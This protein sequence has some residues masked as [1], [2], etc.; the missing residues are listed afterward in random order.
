MSA[1]GQLDP[2]RIGG[3]K[4][5]SFGPDLTELLRRV[6][7]RSLCLAVTG[8]NHGFMPLLLTLIS[9]AMDRPLVVVVV[10]DEVASSLTDALN[11]YDPTADNSPTAVTL[12]ATDVSP[13]D[14]LTPNRFS[15]MD[16]MTALLRGSS[17]PAV[18]YVVASAPALA[19]KIPHR[20]VLTE[21]TITVRIGDTFD[22]DTLVHQLHDLGYY[23]A[24]LVEDPGSYAV[25][26]GLIDI[27]SPLSNLP[28]RIE[29]FGDEVDNIRVFDPQTQRS[30]DHVRHVEIPPITPLAGARE[31]RASAAA[32][33]LQTASELRIPATLA[34]GMTERFTNGTAGPEA[35]AYMPAMYELTTPDTFLP[36]DAVWVVVE[37]AKIETILSKQWDELIQECDKAMA[38]RRIVFPAEAY[39][40]D[41][42]AIIAQLRQKAA[43][44]LA[45]TAPVISPNSIT[46]YVDKNNDI[47]EELNRHRAED[48]ALAPL[49]KHIR[50]WRATA[51]SVAITCH[52]IGSAHRMVGLMR[53]YGIACNL[54]DRSL[55]Y[56]DIET[57]P[58]TPNDVN[59]FVGGT[60]AG[61]RFAPLG[62]VVL[63]E[64]EILGRKGRVATNRSRKEG[65][66][67]AIVESFRELAA[68]DTVVHTDFGLAKYEGLVKL[69]I[70]GIIGDFLH[71]VFRDDD[72]L[73]LPI[74]RLDHIRK[75]ASTNEHEQPLLDKL[76]GTSWAKVT[77]RVRKNLLA[78]AHK[79][80]QIQAEREAERGYPFGPPSEYYREFEA[81]FPYDETPD[82]LSAI[83][84][85]IS[86]VQKPRPMDRLVCGDVGFGKTE[87]AIRA[88]FRAVEEG[89]QVAVLVPTTILAEQHHL[90]FEQRF[91]GYPISVESLSRY[92]TPAEQREILDRV[93]AGKVDVLIGTHRLL[94]KDV[95]FRDLGLL[96]IDEEHRFGVR[97]KERI[98]TIRHGV[99][100]LTLTATPIPR[101]LHMS[102][103]G[104]RDLSVIAT[105]PT[106]RLAI[107]TFVE[108]QTND[109][110]QTAIERE[111]SRGG[112]VYLIHNRVQT[113]TKRAEQ[114]RALVPNAKIGVG[115]GQ[116]PEHQLVEVMR[117]F[118]RGQVNVLV[119]TT[120]VES[121]L[122]IPNAN[123]LIVERADRFGL[124]ELYQLRGRVGRSNVRAYAYFLIEHITHLDGNAA[125]RIA[126]LQRH[127]ELGSGF[128]IASSDMEIR[129]TGNLLGAEQ[130][131][132]I[133][134]VGYELY[135][136]MLQD[137]V[138]ALRGEETVEETDSQIKAP[139]A[140][141]IPD[142]Y[143]S[144]TGMRLVF[145]KR[146]A[147]SKNDN[148]VVDTLR[149]LVDRC[150]KPPIEVQNLADIMA[151]KVMAK[152]LGIE[153][154][155][156]TPQAITL[157]LAPSLHAT[158]RDRIADGAL[159]KIKWFPQQQGKTLALK[160]APAD[161]A[162]GTEF[163][164]TALSEFEKWYATKTV[165]RGVTKL[166]G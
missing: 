66:S 92:R 133:E 18:R 138:S 139:I 56:R 1:V 43:L 151:A 29:F 3:N 26:G 61:F 152:R 112:Q 13:V 148:D 91:H 6:N 31:T 134:A 67:K 72:K 120:I 4:F 65:L 111:I 160:L 37:P 49:V 89:K 48:D 50:E 76:G 78:M 101:T 115:H 54:W 113:I 58:T 80:V 93:R 73:Y 17:F 82:Q 75:Y 88:A 141:F 132:N 154:V 123:T 166:H 142:N 46:L 68:G 44:I 5:E 24:P 103:L 41:T 122:D 2:F 36:Q 147:S 86:D 98:K 11:G 100:V 30:L 108:A 42:E 96:V 10:G 109:V 157:T 114:I 32:T 35:N 57:I 34:R 97:D 143:C 145:Y 47:A 126:V 51:W 28:I 163:L 149:D 83:D 85:V 118:S 117:S 9:R 79:L 140:A 62:L 14:P 8:V 87:V 20:K 153:L 146:F 137:A 39:L 124:A 164:V 22:R 161:W 69:T 84:D 25:R 94:Q 127:S 52:T 77:K 119:C 95:S 64:S 165:D 99:H 81:S 33:L 155:H 38:N 135:L 128:Q 59:I 21:L 144:D 40:A 156:Y 102:L 105:P 16:K 27:Y 129:G 121:G 70:D 90:T 45:D 150:G 53:H 130:H 136:E 71:L 15:T 74:Q 19:R 104:I 63:D 55:S 116:L 158:L 107:R 162:K 131:G 23:F 7:D 159:S 110:I 106:D 12:F 125:K 60:S